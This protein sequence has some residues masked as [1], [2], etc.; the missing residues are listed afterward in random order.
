VRMPVF[1]SPCIV[2]FA[3]ERNSFGLYVNGLLCSHAHM[4]ASWTVGDNTFAASDGPWR[5]YVAL[6][7]RFRESVHTVAL[8]QVTLERVP[9][10]TSEFY[11]HWH[12]LLDGLASDA[13][14]LFE[15]PL[16]G[17]GAVGV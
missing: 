2:T 11:G 10:T 12:A 13:D 1:T 16:V 8:E 14:G 17:G 5:L 3:C 6:Q 9:S 7:H 15:R 4:P